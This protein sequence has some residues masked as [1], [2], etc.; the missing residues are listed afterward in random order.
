MNRQTI[1]LKIQTQIVKEGLV[2]PTEYIQ[3]LGQIEA[4]RMP[5]YI[6]VKPRSLTRQMSGFIRPLTDIAVLHEDYE[7]SLLGE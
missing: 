3:D 2:L 1:G 7:D 4:I 5:C 6:I